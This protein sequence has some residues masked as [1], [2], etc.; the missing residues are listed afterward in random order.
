M[1]SHLA[2]A[3]LAAALA[4]AGLG[5]GAHAEATPPGH[6]AASGPS[7]VVVPLEESLEVRPAAG[8]VFADCSVLLSATPLVTACAPESLTVVGPAYDASI[9]PARVSVPLR[10]GSLAIMVD[11]VIR[12]A[13]PTPPSAPDTTI[14]LPLRAGAV[15]LIPLSELG[16]ECGLCT[17]GTATVEVG[18]VA[19]STLGRARVTGT[20]LV[21]AAAAAAQGRVEIDLRVRDDI[22][23]VSNTFKVMLDV[24]N[25]NGAPLHGLHLAFGGEAGVDLAAADLVTRPDA[26]DAASSEAQRLVVAGCGP[27]LHGAVRCAPGGGI[28][29]E[30]GHGAP[31]AAGRTLPVPDQFA[32]RLVA[33]DGSQ[34]LASVTI[35]AM[36]GAGSSTSPLT[37]AV[38]AKRA[39]LDLLLPRPPKQTEEATGGA[40]TSFTEL[41][42]AVGAR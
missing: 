24:T 13:E 20:H 19:P 5:A 33:P 37:P 38:G 4:V 30:P 28:H 36:S 2:A 16:I 17:P 21:F 40:T 23:A 6:D 18:A 41:M 11:Y 32:V 12:L 42:N 22:G 15:S 9:A 8:W 7:V 14:G 35:G 39:K 25:A 34:T 10:S 27:A 29:Y 31:D 1:P 3:L 26:A